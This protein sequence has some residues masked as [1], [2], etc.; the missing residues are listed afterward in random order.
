MATASWTWRW[1][2]VASR[3]CW[4]TVMGPSRRQGAS[5][6]ADPLGPWPWATS[7]AT[8]NGGGGLEPG[9]VSVLMGNGDGTFLE[10]P[11]Y[12]AGAAAVAV[13]D[14][15]GDGKLDLVTNG[16]VLLGNGDG[17][18]QAP[19]A[20]PAGTYSSVAVGDFNG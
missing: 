12:A 7:M 5:S 15:N 3:C 9:T 11:T 1:P 16:S 8:A 2:V 14:F 4:G 18:F 10:A 6:S 19:L 20:F 13:G 17:T